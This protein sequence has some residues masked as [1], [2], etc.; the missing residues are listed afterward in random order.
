MEEDSDS[1][2]SSLHL[3]SET[4]SKRHEGECSDSTSESSDAYV[5]EPDDASEG[6]EDP[7]MDDAEDEGEEEVEDAG[8]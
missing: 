5:P 4:S 6:N 1:S 2:D 3:G 8:G 7:F